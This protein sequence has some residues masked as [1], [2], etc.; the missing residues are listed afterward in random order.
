MTNFLNMTSKKSNYLILRFSKMR[1][2]DIIKN[3]IHVYGF[4]IKEGS[5]YVDGIK[6]DIN[7]LDDF[8]D[9]L[10]F[11]VNQGISFILVKTYIMSE[12]CYYGIYCESINIS[13]M[14]PS[15]TLEF[16]VDPDKFYAINIPSYYRMAEYMCKIYGNDFPSNLDA[17]YQIVKS[18]NIVVIT[19]LDED[20]LISRSLPNHIKRAV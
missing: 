12:M 2:I 10:V 8:Q 18:M 11:I 19:M 15:I 17:I 7:S 5:M 20:I 14:R 1:P 3:W 16:D 6:I 9:I 13:L 4:D